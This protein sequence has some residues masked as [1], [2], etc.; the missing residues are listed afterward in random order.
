[1]RIGI[2]LNGITR[3]YKKHKWLSFFLI[4]QCFVCMLL[5]NMIFATVLKTHSSVSKFSKFIGSKSYYWISDSADENGDFSRYMKNQNGEYEKLKAFHEC[6]K[7]EKGWRFLSADTQ[8]IDINSS[9]IPDK[10]LFQYERGYPMESKDEFKKSVKCL[11]VSSNVF[12]EFGITVSEG[13]EFQDED[14]YYTAGEYVPI[15]LGHEYKEVFSIGQILD[16]KYLDKTLKFRIMGF[17]PELTEISAPGNRGTLL[18]DRYIVMPAFT[19]ENNK[20]AS[21]FDKVTL[22]QYT[23]G[24]VIS[25]LNYADVEERINR[26]IL[27][28]GTMN[29]AVSP[30]SSNAIKSLTSVS[31]SELSRLIYIFVILTIFTIASMSITINGFIR[32][33]YYEYGVHL[34]SG[35]TP[36]FL[37]MQ[38]I[39][40]IS[41][42]VGMSFILSSLIGLVLISTLAPLISFAFSLVVVILA[43]IF[44]ISVVRKI[45][46]NNLIRRQ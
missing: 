8:P 25:D 4:V 37:V 32:E 27:Q 36:K 35:A 17:L 12:S 29:F 46:V 39:G 22:S 13:R 16:G 23:N 45:D 28:T 34:L 3:M 38:I 19:W 2:V 6:L 18:C 42:V 5:I 1:M 21:W 20:E 30:E 26:Y 14:F 7:N 44:P 41:L 33:N 11:H 9:D 24:I 31:E 43:S 10:F 15:I 40:F